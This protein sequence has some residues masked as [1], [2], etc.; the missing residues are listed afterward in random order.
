MKRGLL[1]LALALILGACMFLC[2]RMM[3]RTQAPLRLAPGFQGESGNLLPELEW[4]RARLRLGDAQFEKVRALHLEY[5]PRCDDLCRRIRDADRSLLEISKREPRPPEL[6]AAL[7]S[8]A[9]LKLECHHAMLDHVH[10]TAACLDPDQ[11]RQYLEI[12]LPHVLGI[13]PACEHCG[14]AP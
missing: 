14:T 9:D 13:P 4:L 2:A 5:R 6:T 8:R 10:R 7:R 11:A 3:T 12:V 1:I